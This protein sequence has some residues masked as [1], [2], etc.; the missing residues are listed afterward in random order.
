MSREPDHHHRSTIG[1]AFDA[2]RAAVPGGHLG[3]QRQ[4]QTIVALPVI[5]AVR[6]TRGGEPVEGALTELP[7][8]AGTIVDDPDDH[9]SSLRGHV[10]SHL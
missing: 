10:D 4:T 2:H 6:L 3:D 7:G 1:A 9:V 8:E 5:V